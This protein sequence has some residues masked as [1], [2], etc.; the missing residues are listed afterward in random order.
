MT[1]SS[2]PRMTLP[3]PILNLNRRPLSMLESN[4]DPFDARVP[5]HPENKKEEERRERNDGRK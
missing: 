1:P 4:F 3:I 2:Q 5:L